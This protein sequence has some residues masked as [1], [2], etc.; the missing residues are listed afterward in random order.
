[1]S[2]TI[3]IVFENNTGLKLDE[4]ESKQV[5][6]LVSKMILQKIKK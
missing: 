6:K 3:T 2:K 4:S 5:L 1:M